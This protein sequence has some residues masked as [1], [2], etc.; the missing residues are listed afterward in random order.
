MESPPVP[1]A[2]MKRISSDDVDDLRSLGWNR[3]TFLRA[4]AKRADALPRKHF[5][6]IKNRDVFDTS[7]VSSLPEVDLDECL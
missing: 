1:D 7:G 6:R 4:K 5:P 2:G 3:T